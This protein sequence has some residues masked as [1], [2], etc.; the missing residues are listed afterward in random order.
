MFDPRIALLAAGAFVSS[1]CSAAPLIDAETSEVLS[2]RIMAAAE[3]ASVPGLYVAV[4]QGDSVIFEHALGVYSPDGSAP[5]DAD[6][7]TRL[8]SATK[9]LTGLTFLSLQE[10]GAIDLDAPLSSLWSEAP[11]AWSNIRL[12]RFLNHTAGL[13]MI[14]SRDDFNALSQEAQLNME[15]D[16]LIELIS[17]DP[18]DFEAGS[19]WRY[20]QSGYLVLVRALERFT[21]KSWD[22]H[23][24]QHVIE[25]SG[26]Q[27]TRFTRPGI[28]QAAAYTLE[29]NVITPHQATYSPALRSGGG[30]DTT[31]ADMTKLFRAL[32]AGE[33]VELDALEAEVGRRDRL[34]RF[35]R[36]I[37]GEGY[38]LAMV[39]QVFGDSWTVGHSGGGGLADIRYAPDEEV[40]IVVLTNR[41]GGSGVASEIADA[42]SETIFGP[43]QRLE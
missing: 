4:T 23:L 39:A 18:V 30:Y 20:Q 24:A 34:H 19:D 28:D 14:V 31:G 32:S 43:A 3:A 27:T 36:N 17:A 41:T 21:G 15:A 40:G 11:A 5:F 13:P 42:I 26:M 2:T 12:W 37:D 10:D 8:A 29:D 9:F 16:A 35:G 25:P 6:T 33:I 38:G 1:A 7:P 22:D